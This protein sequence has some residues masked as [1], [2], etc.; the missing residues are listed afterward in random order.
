MAQN[1]KSKKQMKKELKKKG[2]KNPS[3]TSWGKIIIL[4]LTIA[5]AL[6]SFVTL[7]YYIVTNA[8]TV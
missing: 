4:V 3:D 1:N 2:Y 7:I 6:A 8:S 5:M